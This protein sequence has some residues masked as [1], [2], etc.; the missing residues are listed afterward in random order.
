MRQ[1]KLI[2]GS[3]QIRPNMNMIHMGDN[4][5]NLT[6]VS[7]WPIKGQYKSPNEMIE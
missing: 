1:G 6:G 7:L 2:L 5:D 4:Y 3:V